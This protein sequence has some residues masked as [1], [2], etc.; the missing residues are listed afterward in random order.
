MDHRNRR[1]PA[2][3]SCAASASSFGTVMK[4]CRSKNVA[5]ADAMRGMISP[6]YELI[7][8]Q[9]ADDFVRRHHAHFHRQHQRDEDH[10]EDS[11]RKGKRKYTMAKAESTEMMILPNVIPKETR[12]LLSSS[13]PMLVRSHAS[14]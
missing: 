11:C 7:P 5:V 9:V 2:P 12:V 3:S 14:A 10:P 6:V 8:A 13:R 4:N 1:G